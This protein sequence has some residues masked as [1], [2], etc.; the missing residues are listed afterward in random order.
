MKNWER[1]QDLSQVDPIRVTLP[2]L[3]IPFLIQEQ[4]NHEVVF[5]G[6]IQTILESFQ[7]R[8]SQLILNE[9]LPFMP[10]LACH[11][12]CF[13]TIDVTFSVVCA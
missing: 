7:S 13:R 3:S 5:N 9:M 1:F 6:N 11:E 8:I 4:I 10:R 12:I 2:Q